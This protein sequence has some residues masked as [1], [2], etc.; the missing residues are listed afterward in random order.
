MRHVS[1][2]QYT[3]TKLFAKIPAALWV[4]DMRQP[5]DSFPHKFYQHPNGLSKGTRIDREY[6]AE[7][8]SW[9]LTLFLRGMR[10]MRTKAGHIKFNSKRVKKEDDCQVI[11]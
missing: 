8:G 1:K 9:M 7:G 11:L 3:V 4:I 6:D 10:G 2:S 5:Q